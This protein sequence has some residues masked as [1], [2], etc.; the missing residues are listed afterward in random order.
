VAPPGRQKS[1]L[2]VPRA[3][4]V[5]SD[6]GQRPLP[7]SWPQKGAKDTKNNLIISFTFCELCASCGYLYLFILAIFV[8]YVAI[9]IF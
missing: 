4:A 3:L 9:L 5:W 2:R 1:F 7:V 6:F 8:H